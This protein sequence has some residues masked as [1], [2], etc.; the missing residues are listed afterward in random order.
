MI[1]FIKLEQMLLK[2]NIDLAKNPK[3]RELLEFIADV[4]R[5]RQDEL[6]ANIYNTLPYPQVSDRMWESTKTKMNKLINRTKA[7]IKQVDIPS[8][9]W[10]PYDKKDKTWSFYKLKD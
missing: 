10:L 4:K 3:K 9:E 6:I 8:I 1:S 7:L 5:A 2:L